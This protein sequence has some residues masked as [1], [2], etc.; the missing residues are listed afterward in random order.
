MKNNESHTLGCGHPDVKSPSQTLA[1]FIR[2][3][4]KQ[5]QSHFRQSQS[6]REAESPIRELQELLLMSS[7]LSE[8]HL[9]VKHLVQESSVTHDGTTLFKDLSGSKLEPSRWS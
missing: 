9:R 2:H 1:G 5:S 4:H 3:I 6:Q 7:E 8:Q